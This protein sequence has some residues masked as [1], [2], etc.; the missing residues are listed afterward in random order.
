MR[1]IDNLI[2]E[3]NAKARASYWEMQ[4]NLAY[5]S[6]KIEGSTIS[7]KSNPLYF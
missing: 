3:R 6:N 4:I 5:N 2:S 1:L 7:K